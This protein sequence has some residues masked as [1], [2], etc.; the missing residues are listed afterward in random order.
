MLTK[1]QTTQLEKLISTKLAVCDIVNKNSE[2]KGRY[3]MGEDELRGI[4][5]AL[6][7]MGYELFLDMNP[8]FH[9]NSEKSTFEIRPLPHYECEGCPV[10]EWEMMELEQ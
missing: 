5:M 9:Q 4:K 6:Y 2:G 7:I 3:K 1:I 10:E 8:Y